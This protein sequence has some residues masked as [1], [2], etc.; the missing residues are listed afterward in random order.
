MHLRNKFTIILIFLLLCSIGVRAQ[1]PYK[2]TLKLMGS[3]FDITVVGKD[4]LEANGFIDMAVNEIS[5]I[6]RLISSWDPN[7][8]TS[9]INRNAGIAAVKVDAELFDLIMRAK[10]ISRLTD[11]AFDISYAS[12]DKIWKFDGSMTEMPSGESITNSVA[13]VG[14]DNVLLDKA[15]STVFLKIQGMKIGFGGIGKGYA[16]DSAKDLLISKGVVSGI[17]NASGD[18]NT[19]GKQ[20][21]GSEWKVAITNPMDKN[22][23]FALLP[24]TNGAVVTSGNYEKYVTFNGV[25]YTHII[26]PR[27]GY[28]ATGITSVTVFAPKAELADALATSVFVMGKDV[29]LNRIEQLSKVECI[30]IDAEGNIITSKNIKIKKL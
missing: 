10:G 1:Q 20:P 26:D 14:V 17:I 24:I 5:R 2:R 21:D 11:G 19:W 28:P 25:R 27:T 7:S 29:G 22:K 15:N 12:M 13:K 30:I 23:V 8:Q 9:E 6:E 18:M 4:S 16:A 3:R